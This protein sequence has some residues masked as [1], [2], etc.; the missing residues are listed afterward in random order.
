[1]A[2]METRSEEPEL[3]DGTSVAWADR[4]DALGQ[5]PLVNR[6][7][8]GARA[9][10]CD[11]AVI[12]ADRPA[13]EPL[14]VLD[15]GCGSGDIVVAVLGWAARTARPLRCV[16]LDRDPAALLLASRRPPMARGEV[17]VVRADAFE[18]PLADRS[19]D[20]AAASMMCH[21]FA[22]AG[23]VRVVG[24]LARVADE[25]VIINDL[26]RHRAAYWGFRVASRVFLRGRVVRHDGELSVRRGFR[27]A[28]LW[29]L[30]RR[31]PEF[32]WTVRRRFAFRLCMVGRRVR[33]G[34]ELS[35]SS[36][37]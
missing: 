19:V 30:A 5:L 24:E 2:W 26:H 31:F 7:L 22:G 12:A 37:P 32:R 17:L 8:G 11:L 9:V 16:A 25:A 15:V 35:R 6:F 34:A 1:M 29:E 28:E 33:D 3:L 36:R 14:R 20:V 23:L 4:L 10:L 27:P 13:R 21:H 18:L